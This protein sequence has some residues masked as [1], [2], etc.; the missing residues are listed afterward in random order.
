MANTKTKLP[1][2]ILC[3]LWTA[4]VQR[5]VCQYPFLA[6]WDIPPLECLTQHQSC[7]LCAI[8]HSPMDTGEDTKLQPISALGMACHPLCAD[9]MQAYF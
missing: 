4:C 6:T 2:I 7:Q 8:I 9:Q 5:R 1:P 3:S